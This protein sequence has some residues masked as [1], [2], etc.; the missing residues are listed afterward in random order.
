MSANCPAR[1]NR[2]EFSIIEEVTAGETPELEDGDTTIIPRSGGNINVTNEYFTSNNI[3][4]NRQKSAPTAG[5]Q[6]VAGDLQADYQ[7][8]SFDLMLESVF[9]NNF[10]GNVLKIGDVVKTFTMQVNH[11]DKNMVFQHK[12][13]R[14]NTFSAEINTSGVVT[15][16]FGLLGIETTTSPAT[17][18]DTPTPA[19]SNE[20]FIHIGGTYREGGV[21]TAV[22]TGISFSIDNQISADYAL[23]AETPTCI[24]AAD[25]MVEGSINVFFTS[26]DLYNKFRDGTT[27]SLS[28]TVKDA[29]GNTHTWTFPAIKLKA[30]DI[31]ISDGGSITV[32]IPFEAFYDSVTGTTVQLTRS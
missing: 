6:T 11:K 5:N 32:S 3:N 15:S 27:T 23:G 30:H 20:S 17:I 1:G 28:A 9:R 7:Y 12:G 22:I 16:T 10:A 19:A 8:G 29:D 18:D 14:C 2:T 31:P 26:L 21:V 13:L 24:S 4:S 25:L